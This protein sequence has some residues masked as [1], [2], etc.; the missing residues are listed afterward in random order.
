MAWLGGPRR[1]WALTLATAV[2][3]AGIGLAIALL[4]GGGD[5][6]AEET[7]VP[8]LMLAPTTPPQ[9]PTPSPTATP[10]STA[11]PSPSPAASPSPTVPPTREAASVNCNETPKFCTNVTGLM[12]VEGG[13]LESHGK[14]EH[15]TDYSDVPTS[16]MTWTFLKSDGSEAKEGDEVTKLRVFVV[17]ENKT[18]N[19]T[20]VFPRREIALVTTRNGNELTTPKTTGAS[21]EMPP[22]GK[23]DSSF[24]VPITSDGSY[25]W[26]G[27]TWFYEK[28]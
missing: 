25:E 6:Q 21:F 17:V 28:R 23:L 8:T 7:P 2:V 12:T 10:E 24:E 14:I 22:G 13:D 27:K 5:E 19:R 1:V 9:T 20:F 18:A 3:A 15:S 16:S 11:T 4:A 26:R